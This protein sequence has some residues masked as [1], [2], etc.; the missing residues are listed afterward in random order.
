MWEVPESA[1]RAAAASRHVEIDDDAL[2]RFAA[3]MAGPGTSPPPWDAA[4]HFF[5]GTEKTVAYLMVL[6]TLNFCFW[7]PSGERRWEVRFEDSYLAGYVGLASALTRAM[8]RGAPLDSAAW[9]ARVNIGELTRVLGGRGTLQLMEERAAA[10]RELGRV[11]LTDYGGRAHLLVE[12]AGGSAVALA[13]L[14]AVK[15]PSFRDNALFNGRTVWFL[16]RAQILAADLHGSFGGRHWGMFEDMDRITAFADYKVPQVLRQLGILRYSPELASRVDSLDPIPAGSDEEIE[17][18]AATIT[19]VE[20]MRR[21]SAAA[22]GRLL[23]HELDWML[24]SMGQDDRFR[25]KPYH[26]TVTVFY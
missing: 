8:E 19:A 22:G 17:I 13:R 10:L 4:G 20:R 6:D 12:E 3:R 18:R 1:G 16:K 9:L 2:R 15:L 7:A 14:L 23:P 11:L 26:R 25:E 24:W 21:T 5:D